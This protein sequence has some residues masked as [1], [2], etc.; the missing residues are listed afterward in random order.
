MSNN[1][2]SELKKVAK[3]K[4]AIELVKLKKTGEIVQIWNDIDRVSKRNQYRIGKIGI[5]QLRYD[6]DSKTYIV[7]KE[8]EIVKYNTSENRVFRLYGTIEKE[9]NTLTHKVNDY[10]SAERFMIVDLSQKLDNPFTLKLVMTNGFMYNNKCYRIALE[11]SSQ[12]RKRHN[13]A[14]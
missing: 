7:P 4:R 13:L 3:I 12:A 8:T 6:N 5:A 1:I 14:V 9:L 10:Y 2:K 11:S